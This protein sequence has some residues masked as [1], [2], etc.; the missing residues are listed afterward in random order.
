MTL[1][2]RLS[3]AASMELRTEGVGLSW[4]LSLEKGN[5]VYSNKL[6]VEEM[7]DLRAAPASCW[8]LGMAR[9]PWWLPGRGN[10]AASLPRSSC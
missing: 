2:T 7:C 1:P 4:P 8:G 5:D 10:T 6:N 3:M 9:G